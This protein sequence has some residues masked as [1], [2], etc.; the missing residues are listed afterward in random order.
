MICLPLFVNTLQYSFQKY[1]QITSIHFPNPHFGHIWLRTPF[2]RYVKIFVIFLRLKYVYFLKVWELWHDLHKWLMTICGS[3]PQCS[4][5]ALAI[6]N[7][8]S[9][10][11]SSVT[12]TTGHFSWFL[13]LLGH[14]HLRFG[15]YLGARDPPCGILIIISIFPVKCYDWK[16]KIHWYIFQY[17]KDNFIPITL[18]GSR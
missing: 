3:P 15:M 5:M 1:F 17:I 9:M 12:Q 18:R 11:R 10:V 6:S 4:R 16:K 13:H 7:P 8:N 2:L 14:L